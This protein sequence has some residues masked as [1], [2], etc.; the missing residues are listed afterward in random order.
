[1]KYIGIDNGVTGSI[2]WFDD[3]TGR[4]YH[5][6][7]PVF[8]QTNYTKTKS[9]ITRI[10]FVE[11]QIIFQAF[12]STKSFCLLERPMIN[13]MR[14]KA[15][16][17]AIR[18]LEATLILLEMH[19]I[20]HRYEDSKS[21][22]HALLPSGLEKEELKKASL[23]VAKRLYPYLFSEQDIKDGDGILIA[24]YCRKIEKR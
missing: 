9:N 4:M 22:Q 13:P 21:W 2:A 16:V 12:C 6:K 5:A 11:M 23:D 15:S 17:S 3:S 19:G 24:E 14:W 10:N 18:S 8:S 7:T 20:P 1:M